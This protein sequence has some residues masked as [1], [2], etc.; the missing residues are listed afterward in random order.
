MDDF[1]IV[2]RLKGVEE[3]VWVDRHG[4]ILAHDTRAP[5]QLS[6]LVVACSRSLVAL[7]RDKLKYACFSRACRNN[8]L[9]FPVGNYYLGVVKQKRIKNSEAASA[10]LEFLRALTGKQGLRGDLS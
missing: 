8:V 6:K 2:G 5:E 7:G 1:P 9:I 4:R 10:V 3:F